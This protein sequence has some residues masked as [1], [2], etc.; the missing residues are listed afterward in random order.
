M[1]RIYVAILASVLSATL[2]SQ[3]TPERP[4]EPQNAPASSRTAD[5]R[6]DDDSSSWGWVGLLGLLGLMGL[7]GRRQ[8]D[9]VYGEESRDAKINRAA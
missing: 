4:V 5:A 9:Y 1:R 8:R 3:A 2:M 7:G 6:V